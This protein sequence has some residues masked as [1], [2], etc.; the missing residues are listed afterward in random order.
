MRTPLA[1]ALT[2]PPE[3]F[4]V[5][6]VYLGFGACLWFMWAVLVGFSQAWF[7]MGIALYGLLYVLAQWEPD[8]FRV[9]SAALG[10]VGGSK[11]S[12]GQ[13]PNRG[14]YKGH[15]YFA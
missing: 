5:P 6:Y 7:L 13:T 1:K 9:L 2:R 12:L 8:F 3:F 11:F 14:L 10:R 4:G 15:K